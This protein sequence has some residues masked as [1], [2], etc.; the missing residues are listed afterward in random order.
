MAS[1]VVLRRRFCGCEVVV[2]RLC[3]VDAAPFVF[4]AGVGC[5]VYLECVLACSPPSRLAL[6]S[7]LADPGAAAGRSR[8]S[9]LLELDAGGGTAM[10]VCSKSRCCTFCTLPDGTLLCDDCCWELDNDL[11]GELGAAFDLVVVLCVR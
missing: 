3:S 7:T 1:I 4:G 2:D 10:F 11:L 8:D 6:D 9:L 5:S